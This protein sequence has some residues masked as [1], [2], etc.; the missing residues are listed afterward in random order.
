MVVDSVA[1]HFRQDFG[2][3]SQRTRILNGMAQQL[4]RLAAKH[5]LA[6]VLINQMTTK[7]TPGG[8]SRLVPALG[9]RC[10]PEL[11][12]PRCC[13][14]AFVFGDMLLLPGCWPSRSR[15]CEPESRGIGSWKR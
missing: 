11:L 3:M 15:Y 7:V 1:F 4:I 2:D 8:Q 6:V 9:E 5:D 10:V 14:C 13:A 12:V